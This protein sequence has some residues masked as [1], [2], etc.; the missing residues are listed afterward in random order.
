MICLLVFSVYLSLANGQQS[1][2][3]R[4]FATKSIVVGS[5]SLPAGGDSGVISSTPHK[6]LNTTTVHHATPSVT[7]KPSMAPKPSANKTQ[8][9]TST[10]IMTTSK[11]PTPSVMTSNIQ[12]FPVS[13]H[14]VTSSVHPSPTSATNNTVVIFKCGE[15]C[16]GLRRK[17]YTST[18]FAVLFLVVSIVLSL[19][20]FRQYQ[21][22]KDYINDPTLSRLI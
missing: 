18:V 19:L 16:V 2:T 13:T 10:S 4:I 17:L 8:V 1:P 21:I 22:T 5:S 9:L 12:L 6:T 20:L 14:H 3:Q 7:P 11:V 15:E